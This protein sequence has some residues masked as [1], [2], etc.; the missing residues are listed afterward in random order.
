[1]PSDLRN[2]LG[3]GSQ[4]DVK[5]YLKTGNWQVNKS[6]VFTEPSDFQGRGL[7]GLKK[8]G[9]Q[10]YAV[11]KSIQK[12]TRGDLRPYVNVPMNYN[13]T[14]SGSE[15]KTS[16]PHDLSKY[17]PQQIKNAAD[18]HV[19]VEALV[20]SQ[21]RAVKAGKGGGL[22]SKAEGLIKAG[23]W[24][25]FDY[26]D[27]MNAINMAAS[28]KAA[29]LHKKLRELPVDNRPNSGPSKASLA[30]SDAIEK[31]TLATGKQLDALWN[32]WTEY[33]KI[34]EPPPDPKGKKKGGQGGLALGSTTQR[35]GGAYNPRNPYGTGL[36]R[37][38]TSFKKNKKQKGM[39][40]SKL[41][42]ELIQQFKEGSDSDRLKKLKEQTTFPQMQERIR[43]A[44][45]KRR[46]QQK[47]SEKLYM[48][49]KKKGVKFYDKKG[50]GRLK[51]GKKVYD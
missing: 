36:D 20:N 30:L 16:G 1:M 28:D 7:G 34:E 3:N 10:V 15:A 50:T 17:T 27:R 37:G 31:I 46:E 5:Q 45:E 18:R 21:N 14:I 44:K 6:F 43:N 12:G 19:S 9:P 13:I 42:F 47:K 33:N 40:E 4:L 35:Q 41:S 25:W 49:T 2:S 29:P 26:I 24:S 38:D 22:D 11:G 23:N 51:D 8:F 32:A 39:K 48:D